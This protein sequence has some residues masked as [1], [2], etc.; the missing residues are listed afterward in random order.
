MS[1]ETKVARIK[2]V[3]HAGAFKVRLRWIGEDKDHTVDLHKIVFGVKG[4]SPIRDE[5]QF[6]KV[7][8]GQGGHSLAWPGD[9]DVGAD[10]LWEIDQEQNGLP[11]V[12]EFIHWRQ[13]NA[14]SLK[15]A[16]DALGVSRRM[17]A[18]YFSGEK[19]VPRYIL[20]ACK[21]WD[22]ANRKPSANAQVAH[23]HT[24]PK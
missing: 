3:R 12:A 18:Y 21:G 7:A 8:V 13:R 1:I 2:S 22:A 4:L 11:G 20:L 17:I 10:R 16:S 19:A 6:A 24:R 14:F 23:S 5:T 15:Q 9:L